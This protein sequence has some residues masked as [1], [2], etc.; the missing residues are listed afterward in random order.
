MASE[1][2]PVDRL[3]QF[4]RELKPETRALLMTELERSAVD[5]GEVAGADLILQELRAM[6]TEASNPPPRIPKPSRL[7]FQPV[8]PF[9]VDDAPERKQRGRIARAALEPIWEFVG[10]DLLADEAA[11]FAAEAA[12]CIAAN[13]TGSAERA[14][15]AFQ[16]AVVGALEQ[17]FAAADSDDKAKRRL[18]G[19]V[20]SP[21]ALDDLRNLHAILK[22]RDALA[23][24]GARL[25]LHIRNLADDQLD[26]VK[27]VLESPVARHSHIALHA[28]LLVMSRL[29]SPW[30]LIR[31]GVR[32]AESDVA[33]R[34]AETPFAIAVVLVLADIEGRVARLRDSLKRGRVAEAVAELKEIHDAAR[35]LRSEI[36]LSV[37]S[38][39][40]RQLAAVR[41]EVS[42]LL[43]TEVEGLAGRMRRLLRPRPSK[44]IASGAVI[45]L[46]DVAETEAALDLLGACRNVASELAMNEVALR[47]HSELQNYLD[48]GT[49]ALLDSFRNAGPADRAFRKSQVDAAIGFSAKLFGPNYAS[50]LAK[51][52]EVAGQSERKAA[53][54]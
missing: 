35:G 29:G 9:V 54:A 4:L 48:T 31:L 32:A 26:A 8:E 49:P 45:D 39:W 3:R 16:D 52:A 14:A 53:K 33:A 20:G 11:A 23:T 12:R 22:G 2:L 10:R 46:G 36:D 24:I 34:I 42:A 43:R 25:P 19:Q 6:M 37:D 47:V 40:S 17:V 38:P 15:R 30:Q 51:A 13:D 27:A 44:E 41:A 7:F 50:L 18:A 1:G 28:I 21:H 5:G